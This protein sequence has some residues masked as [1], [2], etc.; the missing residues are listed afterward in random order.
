VEEFIKSI[1]KIPNY[2]AKKE[3]PIKSTPLRSNIKS[4]VREEK[5]PVLSA[6][7]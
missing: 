3:E 7:K 4:E 1:E 5:Q 2:E 6:K